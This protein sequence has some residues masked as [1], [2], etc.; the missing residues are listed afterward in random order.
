MSGT[1]SEAPCT[2]NRRLRVRNDV[3]DLFFTVDGL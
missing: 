1:N 3:Y 2:R